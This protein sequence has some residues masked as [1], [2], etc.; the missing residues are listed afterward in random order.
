MRVCIGA[1]NENPSDKQASFTVLLR[2]KL[3][4]APASCKSSCY[5]AQR[6]FVILLHNTIQQPPAS[7]LAAFALAFPAVANIFARLH[8]ALQIAARRLVKT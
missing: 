5:F 1:A 3:A 2:R 8:D 4:R 7:C 6:G